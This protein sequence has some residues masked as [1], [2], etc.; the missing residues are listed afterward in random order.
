MHRIASQIRT[1][2]ADVAEVYE[3]LAQ[4]DKADK[5]DVYTKDD[6]DNKFTALISGAPGTLDALAELADAISNNP[7]YAG[8]SLISLAAKADKDNPTCTG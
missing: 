6:T 5:A 8:N 3:L 1:L 2:E 4:R 7:D